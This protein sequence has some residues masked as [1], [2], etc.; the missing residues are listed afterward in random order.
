M[1]EDVR[2]KV[3]AKGYRLFKTKSW[4][5]F[6]EGLWHNNPIFGMILGLCSTLAVTNLMSN[7]L[8]MSLAV[9]AVLIVNSA[10][11]SLLRNLIPERVRMIA[12]MLIISSLVIT[13]DLT[14][15]IFVPGISRSLGPYVALI[16]TNCIIMGRAEAFA[17]NN[18]VGIV[19]RTIRIFSDWISS[20]HLNGGRGGTRM[21]SPEG[22]STSRSRVQVQ[23]GGKPHC[24]FGWSASN[25][26]FTPNR[27]RRF[28][29][30]STLDDLYSQSNIKIKL[31]KLLITLTLILSVL[32]L[33]H[34]TDIL[35]QAASG[36]Y[37]RVLPD[38]L[39]LVH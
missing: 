30:A 23:V 35:P 38:L 33:A 1:A 19:L 37:L 26:I 9:T 22:P 11:I 32:S 13:V 12:Y 34:S 21:S 25:I 10:L 28:F 24:F 31:I 6:M 27:I 36:T 2:L 39:R 8:V 4:M 17:I 15:K 16:I 14:L 7:A 20:A 3:P 5:V 29:Y 18:P